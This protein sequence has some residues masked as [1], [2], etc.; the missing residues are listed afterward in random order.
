MLGDKADFGIFKK[1]ETISSFAVR[2]EIKQKKLQKTYR[3]R[4]NN[5]LRKN[6]WVFEESKEEIKKHRD[7]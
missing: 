2:L 7:K 4:L 6:Q 1:T 5:I 3:W